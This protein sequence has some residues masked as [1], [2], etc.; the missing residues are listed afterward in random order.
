MKMIVVFE[1]QDNSKSPKKPFN[2]ELLE[3][4]STANSIELATVLVA[5]TKS[6]KDTKKCV[7]NHGT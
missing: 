1:F 5:I 2:S 6:L 4:T 7:Q 3:A